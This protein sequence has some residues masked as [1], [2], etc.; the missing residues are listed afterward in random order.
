MATT[1]SR[2]GLRKPDPIDLVNVG[3]DLNNNLDALDAAV[4]VAVTTA[5][6]TNPY[7]GK[8]VAISTD[9]YRSYFSNGTAPASGS[10]VELLN[11]SGTFGSDIK[12][13]AGKKLLI[14]S[15]VNLYRSAANVLQ[16]DDSLVVAGSI[17]AASLPVQ[18]SVTTASA[19]TN[20][21]TGWN[22][23][24][25]LSTACAAGALYRVEA[26]LRFQVSINTLVPQ[27]ALNCPAS[28][29]FFN[30]VVQYETS[31]AHGTATQAFEGPQQGAAGTAVTSVNTDLVAQ[32]RALVQPSVA[33]SIV[34]QISQNA[35]VGTLTA[36]AG[37]YMVVQQIA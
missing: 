8:A 14:G 17:T 13:A 25:G 34:T 3:A 36:K 21:T 22:S 2:L 20:T 19:T 32:I 23:V 37:S 15:D 18:A 9:S 7:A 24:T 31:T 4:G 6:P 29:T 26:Y 35:A 16:T 28:P 11:S 27:F 33:G 1:T 5:L 30:A 12:L 10:W